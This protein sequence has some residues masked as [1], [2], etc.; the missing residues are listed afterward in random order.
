MYPNR[1]NVCVFMDIGIDEHD[2]DVRFKS[3]NGNIAVSCMHNV[4]GHN[5]K[6]ISV[7]VNLAI[8]QLPRS[9]LNLF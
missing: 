3:G 2:G 5:Y 1:R 6:N 4:S 8:G 7:I 9:N